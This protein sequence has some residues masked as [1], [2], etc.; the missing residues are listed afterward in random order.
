MT[1]VWSGRV[2]RKAE[3]CRDVSG[4][5]ESKAGV[6]SLAGVT[7]GDVSAP[8]RSVSGGGATERKAELQGSGEEKA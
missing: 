1:A 3:K 8:R 6:T 7:F 4:K 2:E 5:D